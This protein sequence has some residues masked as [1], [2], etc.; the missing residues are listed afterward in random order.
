VEYERVAS[1]KLTVLRRMFDSFLAA[2]GSE[3]FRNYIEAEG[4]LLH[5]FAVYCVLDQE[6]HRA[7]PNVW[8][9]PNW[10]AQYQDPDSPAIEEFAQCHP[11]SVL[12][13]KFLQWQISRQLADAQV[14]ALRKGMALGLYHDLALATDRYGADVWAYRRFYVLGC[15][16]GSP[17]DDFSPHGQDWSFPP[18]NREAHRENGY[19]VFAQSIRKAA[20]HGGALRIDHVM[21]F[22][23]LYWIPQG[24]PATGGAYV[25]DRAQDLL[26]I[27]ALE[28]VRGKFVV[29][30]ED[31]GTVTEEVRRT[32][33]ESGVLSYRL[34]WFERNADGSFRRPDEYPRQA[35]V[36]ATTHDLA[37]LAGFSSGR[38]IDARVAAG[39][40][41][42]DEFHRQKAAREN[43]VRYLTEALKVAGFPGD[44]IGFAL[45]TPCA[46]AL[47][48]VEDLSGETEQQNLPGSTWQY[49][50]WRRKMNVA[51]ED[52]GALA[53]QFAAAVE[54]SSRF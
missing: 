2:G 11:E 48:S 10:P 3:D 19:E 7:D 1:L 24:M 40:I 43:D 47:V 37:T 46:L 54:R 53:A 28:S 26:G 15:R 32:L 42:D 4:A 33:A 14:R 22:A 34:L 20:E 50:N 12:F 21:R 38:D 36:S 25:G 16:V 5:R 45:A 29:V 23:H 39:L 44:A 8:I 41:D 17:P 31:L 27:L 6:L 35:L 13:Y 9:W 30:G 49:P 51:V 18:P 52:F